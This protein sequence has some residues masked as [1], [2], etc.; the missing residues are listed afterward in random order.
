MIEKKKKKKGRLGIKT[1]EELNALREK[2]DKRES[3][4]PETEDSDNGKI[5]I[6]KKKKL[7]TKI[8]N[9]EN[10]I[11]ALQQTVSGC[12]RRIKR[13]EE[14]HSFLEKRIEG[15]FIVINNSSNNNHGERGNCDIIKIEE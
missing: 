13:L 14:K 5:S 12:N 11:S 6:K 10:L 3:L 4:F 2:V 8:K 9:L 15:L 1:E 7:I